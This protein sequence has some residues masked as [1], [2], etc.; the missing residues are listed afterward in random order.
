MTSPIRSG[1]SSPTVATGPRTSSRPMPAIPSADGS[2]PT[3]TAATTCWR[4]R[5][6]TFKGPRVYDNTGLMLH[7]DNKSIVK[8]RIYLN[9]SKPGILHNEITVI[10]N[11]LTRPWTVLK[12]Y[13]RDPDAATVL[14]R[15]WLWRRQQP[16][17]HRQRKLFSERGR[18]PDARQ[19]GSGAAGFAIFQSGHRS[20]GRENSR[21]ISKR[22]SPR[23]SSRQHC[24]WPS[25]TRRR[26]TDRNIPT[27]RD[28]GCGRASRAGCL[29][30][31]GLR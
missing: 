18:P 11:A 4:S 19:E 5:P 13:R 21:A 16:H 31:S 7:P 8:E 6:A 10:D 29:P 24:R 15:E 14:A 17:P 26:S 20:D 1:G 30:A 9:R 2:I 27:G 25:P 12:S 22:R 28:S 23:S 3:A